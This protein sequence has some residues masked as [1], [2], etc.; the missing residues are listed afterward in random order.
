[1]FMNKKAEFC[2]FR[3]EWR[4]MDG[5]AER[6]CQMRNGWHVCFWSEAPK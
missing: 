4:K 3:V 2:E 1:M 6:F 5:N